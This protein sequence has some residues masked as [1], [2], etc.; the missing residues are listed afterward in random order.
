MIEPLSGRIPPA[1]DPRSEARPQ[2]IP[3]AQ[4]FKH[5][6]TFIA[7]FLKRLGARRSDID[8]LV[9]E[10][11][12]IAH[13]HGGFADNGTAKPT[14]WLSAIAIR[15]LANH[16]RHQSRRPQHAVAP[17]EGPVQDLSDNKHDPARATAQRRAIE[18]IEEA[19]GALDENHR[20]IFVLYEIEGESCVDIA[21][22]LEI[23]VGT[24]YSR[25]HEARKR[26]RAAYEQLLSPHPANPFAARK[27]PLTP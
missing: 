26:F 15:V 23:P 11:F 18:R 12:V 9:Q 13:R 27:A 8:D 7:A 4:L 6:S 25:L 5:H 14:T 10:V 17:Q 2:L 16:R 21:A 3:A 22:V 19:L 20:G 24:V 1:A